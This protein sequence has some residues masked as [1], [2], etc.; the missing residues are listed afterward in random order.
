[1]SRQIQTLVH[2]LELW[3][4][5]W[6]FGEWVRSFARQLEVCHVV[7]NFGTSL[8]SFTRQVELWHFS[9]NSGTSAKSFARHYRHLERQLEI[10]RT[11]TVEV[12]HSVSFHFLDGVCCWRGGVAWE[13]DERRSFA[14]NF[15]HALWCAHGLP[16][17]IMGRE[18]PCRTLRFPLDF[19]NELRSFLMHWGK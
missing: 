2:Q 3:H 19:L 6:N 16:M 10:V 4:V 13:M 8:R 11:V 18:T 1:M 17:G 15:Q 12:V 5:S 7:K 14:S 9:W